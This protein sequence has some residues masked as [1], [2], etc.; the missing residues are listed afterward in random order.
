MPWATR[1]NP[2]F[3]RLALADHREQTIAGA[4]SAAAPRRRRPCLSSPSPRPSPPLLPPCP[5]SFF[6]RPFFFRSFLTTQRLGSCLNHELGGFNPL[7]SGA[8]SPTLGVRMGHGRRSRPPLSLKRS[9]SATATSPGP[10]PAPPGWKAKT[11]MN[12]P[13]SDIVAERVRMVVRR[14]IPEAG[15]APRCAPTA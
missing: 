5:A 6:A 8:A 11:S 4:H 2:F 10:S 9:S 13:D 12:T 7:F 14:A 15:N 1:F 3:F